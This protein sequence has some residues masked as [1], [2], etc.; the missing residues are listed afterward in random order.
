MEPILLINLLF[1][2]FYIILGVRL[3]RPIPQSWDLLELKLKLFPPIFK[4]VG[5]VLGIVSILFYIYET[6]ANNLPGAVE[7]LLYH[8]SFG[9]LL[10]IFSREKNE[11]ELIGQVRLKAIVVGLLNTI[12]TYG[13][14]YPITFYIEEIHNEWIFSF[15]AILSM[16][17]LFYLLYFYI[18]LIRM[19]R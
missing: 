10:L 15:G 6:K 4:L 14:M 5:V 12:F 16:F 1:T 3:I 9:I 11:D 17:G 7:L 18:T 13:F 19:R 2:L 8:F